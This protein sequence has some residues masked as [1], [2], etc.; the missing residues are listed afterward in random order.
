[1]SQRKQ[2][3]EIDK[4]L[5]NLF[6][7]GDQAPWSERQ[8]QLFSEILKDAADR[9]D[10]SVNEFAQVLEDNGYMGMVQGYIFEL[11]ATRYWDNE[12]FCLV[13]DY[14]KRRGWREAPRAKRYLQSLAESEVQLWEVTAVNAGYWVDVRPFGTTSEVIRVHER[15]GSQGLRRWDCVAARVISLDGKYSFGGG[16]LPFLPELA[17]E[18]P[19]LMENSCLSTIA[20]LKE[21][22]AENSEFP[23]SD[24]EIEVIAKEEVDRQFEELLF[25]IWVCETYSV[26]TNPMPTLLNRDGHHLQ[27]SKIKFPVNAADR[28]EIERRLHGVSHFDFNSDSEEWIWL[29]SDSDSSD[30]AWKTALGQISMTD[31]HLTAAVN[32]IE[33]GEEIK[34]FLKT[35]LGELVGAP[36]AVHENVQSMMG[37]Y[38][39]HESSEAEPIDAQELLK[40]YMDQHYRKVLDE[41]IPALNNRTPRDCAQEQDQQATLVRWLKSLENST[42]VSPQMAPYDFT[43]MWEELGLEHMVE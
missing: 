35:L 27:W 12:D 26:I 4:A 7:Y 1:M 8:E 10:A 42:V 41:P 21:I 24:E 20:S 11:F 16:V 32:S 14:L 17:Q 43:W 3:K 23:W 5:T 37:S 15:M 33:R 30:M 28:G 31:H 29:D 19:V 2:Q 6:K 25:L 38:S 40:A 13:D 22:R 39:V 18:I 9:A 36:L 34:S